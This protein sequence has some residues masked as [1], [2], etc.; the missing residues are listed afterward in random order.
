MTK[1]SKFFSAIA[2][3]AAG[4]LMITTTAYQS[5]AADPTGMAAAW[6]DYETDDDFNAINNLNTTS[7]GTFRYVPD[8]TES[9]TIEI[10]SG[11]IQSLESAVKGLA[12]Q[13]TS[14]GNKARAAD[15]ALETDVTTA[16][17][18]AKDAITSDIA[19]IETAI[20]S[21]NTTVTNLNTTTTNNFA[22]I[23]NKLTSIEN[24]LNNISTGSGGSTGAT[25]KSWTTAGTYTW[26]VPSGVTTIN[27]T[28]AKGGG[29][30]GGGGGGAASTWTQYV[31]NSS[32]VWF[33]SSG[34]GGTS[35]SS[36]ENT[37]IKDSSGNIL[38]NVSGGTGGSGG[39][40]CTES[41]CSD[42]VSAAA[43]PSGS[44]GGKGGSGGRGTTCITDGSTDVCNGYPGHQGYDASSV[45]NRSVSVLP[46]QV[47]TITVGAGGSGGA[48]GTGGI[49]DSSGQTS[50]DNGSA[51]YAGGA[52]YVHISW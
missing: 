21:L 28:S 25:S 27:V 20:G 1:K 50:G 37:T 40:G 38:L 17:A 46:G 18:S 41:S 14:L 7:F 49:A 16:V 31:S 33:L 26:T 48:G 47:L 4:A 9:A 51:G 44:N 52:G 42:S 35:G 6:A 23:N 24:K 29:G 2:I 32:H 39:D 11:D 30:G 43:V 34:S 5:K 13:V 10:K 45:T 3:A 19:N 22:T 15:T 12:R 36:G 8:G